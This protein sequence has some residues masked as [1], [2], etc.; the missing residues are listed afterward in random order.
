MLFPKT[1][2]R[3][4]EGVVQG[5][6]MKAACS[7]KDVAEHGRIRLSLLGG[8]SLANGRRD[9]SLPASCQRVLAYLALNDQPTPR[10]LVAGTLWLDAPEEQAQACLRSA[11]WRIRR[12]AGDVVVAT[13]SRLEIGGDVALDVRAMVA[14]SR[15]LIEGDAGSV[16]SLPEPSRLSSRLLPGWYDDWV[17]FEQERLRQLGAYALEELAW[18]LASHGRFG[19]AI[20][21]GL[22]AVRVEPLRESAHRVVMAIHLLQGNRRDALR[23][24]RSLE[25]VLRSDLDG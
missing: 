10:T 20:D 13:G 2:H 14:V 15:A 9:V 21:A 4:A 22:T 5:V 17:L 25:R 11:L 24:F 6:G 12:A 18:L 16:D 8:F 3:T 19:A 7:L 1:G 23:Q